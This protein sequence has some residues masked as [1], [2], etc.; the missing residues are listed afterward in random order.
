MK[1][2]W[3]SESVRFR[4]TPGELGRLR[5]GESVSTRLRVPGGS[6][7]ATVTPGG[8]PTALRGAGPGALTLHL[9]VSDLERLRDPDAEGVY[10]RPPGGE[11]PVRYFI[12]KDFPCAHPR[13]AEAREDAETFDPP[14]GFAERHKTIRA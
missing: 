7:E 12:E 9:A 6:W 5:A 8:G 14:P 11:A 3:T 1:V 4:I 2:R 13:P 10:F